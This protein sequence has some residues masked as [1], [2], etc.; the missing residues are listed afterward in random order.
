M[1]KNYYSLRPKGLSQLTPKEIIGYVRKTTLSIMGYEGD[2]DISAYFKNKE[3]FFLTSISSNSFLALMNSSADCSSTDR[4][5]SSL[6]E[7][8]DSWESWENLKRLALPPFYEMPIHL[9]YIAHSQKHSSALSDI[10]KC[11]LLMCC[12][13]HSCNIRMA[14]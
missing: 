6:P 14:L 3:R 9:V 7:A 5:K 1:N 10:S 8:K 11:L 4:R 2:R 13:S 12:K